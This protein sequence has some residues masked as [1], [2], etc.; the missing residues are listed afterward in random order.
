MAHFVQIVDGVV[1]N[2]IVVH[3][4]EL[5]VD[6]VEN[7]V[8]GAEFCHNLLGGEWIQ[9][10]YNNN[11]R[12]QYASVGFTYDEATQDFVCPPPPVIDEP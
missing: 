9:T 11:F 1:V 5:L 6:G 2:N 7:E 8:K 10:S 12:K 3:N 4:N